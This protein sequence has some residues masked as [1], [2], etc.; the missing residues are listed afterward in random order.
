MFMSQFISQL[1]D[2]IVVVVAALLAVGL[3][4]FSIY[5]LSKRRQMLN[6]ERMATVVKGLYYSGAAKDIFSKLKPTPTAMPTS[7]PT[8]TSRD[9]L[10]KGLRWLFGAAG[11][12]LALF[13]FGSLQ[14]DGD[15]TTGL[16]ASLAGIVPALIGLAHFLFSII[17]RNRQTPILPVRTVSTGPF[18]HGP[19]RDGSSRDESFRHRTI[20]HSI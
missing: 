15:P 9:H 3:G 14:P 16:R 5:Y 6:Q 11:L 20:R 17:T 10:L 8:T 1:T 18:R 19:V 7:K 2:N 12:S 4:A 13:T